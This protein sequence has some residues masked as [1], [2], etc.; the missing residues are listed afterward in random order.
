[1]RLCEERARMTVGRAVLGTNTAA[2]LMKLERMM[3]C[4]IKPKYENYN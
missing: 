3:H 4:N 2:I 1:M